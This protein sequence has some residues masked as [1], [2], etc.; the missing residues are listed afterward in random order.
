MW[1]SGASVSLIT[2]RATQRLGIKGKNTTLSIVKVGDD[3]TSLDSKK[4][5]VPLEDLKGKIW[6]VP[7]YEI[8]EI[9]A[10]LNQ[11]DAKQ[12]QS[13]FPE[14]DASV[15]AKP[16]GKI[17]MLIGVDSCA[18]MPTVVR[19]VGNSQLLENQF[20]LCVRG[21]FERKNEDRRATCA[22]RSDPD[23]TNVKTPLH[24]NIEELGSTEKELTKDKGQKPDHG[25]IDG[26]LP[27]CTNGLHHNLPRPREYP[28]TADILKIHKSI[29]L[30]NCGDQHTH[31]YLKR[32]ETRTDIDFEE[33]RANA[34]RYAL[35]T[36]RSRNRL[37]GVV[38]LTIIDKCKKRNSEENCYVDC[39][40]KAI[41]RGR[42][43]ATNIGIETQYIS[44]EINCKIKDCTVIGLFGSNTNAKVPNLIRKRL[45]AMT[46]EANPNSYRLDTKMHLL[47]RRQTERI[48]DPSSRSSTRS[49]TTRRPKTRSADNEYWRRSNIVIKWII[50]RLISLLKFVIAIVSGPHPN[51]ARAGALN[52]CN[53]KY[54]VDHKSRNLGNSGIARNWRT[55]DETFVHKKSIIHENLTKFYVSVYS[56]NRQEAAT[57]ETAAL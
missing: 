12:I 15:I 20:G 13:H 38:S 17:D 40:M 25:K 32:T 4:V 45:L 27:D 3:H 39:L 54:F 30:R 21:S 6:T 10:N 37:N 8:D 1:D 49:I 24:M 48:E 46:C 5:D 57:D 42:H 50:N 36:F 18:I 51:S 2:R 43:D 47:C 23:E 56:L 44:I 33:N 26:D 41:T 53:V 29:H 55:V 7:A 19:T 31:Q 22:I 11:L 35:T 9:T 16:K 28:V 34:D 14:I 52:S